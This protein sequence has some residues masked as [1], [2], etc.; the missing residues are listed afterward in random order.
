MN[1][2][3]NDSIVL[4]LRSIVS[5]FCHKVE[6]SI[7]DLSTYSRATTNKTLRT[8]SKVL[9]HSDL[10]KGS[11]HI[12]NNQNTEGTHQQHF[13]YLGRNVWPDQRGHDI[14]VTFS[15]LVVY[16]IIVCNGNRN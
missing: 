5:S 4:S 14:L 1:S 8:E 9:S 13:T 12:Y 16:V 10:T 3:G 7:V 11:A 6:E 2:R 15:F